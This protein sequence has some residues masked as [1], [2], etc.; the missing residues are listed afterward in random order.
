M[1]FRHEWTV[2]PFRVRFPAGGPDDL[3]AYRFGFPD[4]EKRRCEPGSNGIGEIVHL[5]EEHGSRAGKLQDSQ[6]IFVRLRFH[7]A[8]HAEQLGLKEV[9]RHGRAPHRDERL[10]VGS[11][12]IVNAACKKGA[13][14]AGLP[15]Q[16]NEPFP[17]PD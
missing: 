17:P 1:E 15:H 8:V 11:A 7:L 4:A 6:S 2:A 5:V 12:L 16:E 13:P 10:P 14:C 3:A 9:G